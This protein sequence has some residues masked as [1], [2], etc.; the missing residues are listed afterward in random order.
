[1]DLLLRGEKVIEE[2]SA[3][4]DATVEKIVMET[5]HPGFTYRVTT[6]ASRAVE[7]CLALL[8]LGQNEKEAK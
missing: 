1:M 3:K 4:E 5:V 8:A 7:E 2:F 6:A